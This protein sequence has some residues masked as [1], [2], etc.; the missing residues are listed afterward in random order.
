MLRVIPNAERTDY[1][2]KV[3]RE[4]ATGVE[5]YW[6]GVRWLIS[7]PTMLLLLLVPFTLAIL[8]FA[9]GIWLFWS[10]GNAWLTK[11]LM[12]WFVNWNDHW[13]WALAYTVVKALMWFSILLVCLVTSIVV[14]G[15]VSSPVYELISAKIERELLGEANHSVPLAQMPRLI[16]GEIMK[17]VIV[18]IVPIGLMIIPGVNLFAGF[19]AAFLLGWDFYDYPLARRGWSLS[20]RWRFVRSEFWT[21]LGFGIWLVIPIAQILFVPMAVAGGTILNIEALQRRGLVAVKAA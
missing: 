1:V 2:I 21:V 17:A 9:G 18:T 11:L 6:R 5:G 3:A 20:K 13:A 7:K 10:M 15:V 12:A 4:F 19:I 8:A 14:A 16:L